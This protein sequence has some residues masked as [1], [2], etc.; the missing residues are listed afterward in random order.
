MADPITTSCLTPRCQAG[1]CGTH[2]WFER[3]SWH[4][5]ARGAG[6]ASSRVLKRPTTRMAT[7]FA[8]LLP[9]LGPLIGSISTVDSAEHVFRALCCDRWCEKL[10]TSPTGELKHPA[11]YRQYVSAAC[12]TCSHCKH[13]E[14]HL[15]VALPNRINLTPAASKERVRKADG[16]GE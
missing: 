8:A 2:C 5:G 6:S 3:M 13:L 9:L 12:R 15:Q 4:G 14:Q 1:V 7:V 11:P 16:A 10:R